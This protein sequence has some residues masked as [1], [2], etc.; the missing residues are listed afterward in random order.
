M[1]TDWCRECGRQLNPSVTAQFAG[2]SFSGSFNQNGVATANYTLNSFVATAN[3]ATSTLDFTF[4]PGPGSAGN[5]FFGLDSVTVTDLGAQS[6]PEFDFQGGGA[7][8][9]VVILL[10][11]GCGSLA[12]LRRLS[13][14]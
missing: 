11:A 10:L 7:V 8:A 4:D 5:Q 14:T 13:A 1:K 12:M 9:S 2:S 6:A 3:A